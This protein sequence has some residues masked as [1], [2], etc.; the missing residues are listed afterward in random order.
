MKYN[1]ITGSRMKIS[2]IDE[3]MGFYII[4]SSDDPEKDKYD[5]SFMSFILEVVK[6]CAHVDDSK[7]R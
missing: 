7:L 4:D 2:R 3:L 1:E 6:T 5:M